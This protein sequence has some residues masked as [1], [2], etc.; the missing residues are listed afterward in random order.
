MN[1][2]NGNP[3]NDDLYISKGVLKARCD[4]S[5]CDEH[6]ARASQGT[7]SPVRAHAWPHPVLCAPASACVCVEVACCGGGTST[8]ESVK[9][10]LVRSSHGCGRARPV[11]SC[12]GNLLWDPP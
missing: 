1:Q 4:L 10:T 7:R 5:A 9:T 6:E 2:D 11:C 3:E 8:G 12:A